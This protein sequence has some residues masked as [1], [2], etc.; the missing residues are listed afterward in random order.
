[1]LGAVES[2][3]HWLSCEAYREFRDGIDPELVRR[4]RVHY[5]R[6]VIKKRKVLEKQLKCQEEDDME[7][8]DMEEDDM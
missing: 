6:K 7:E 4:D 5:L 2:P 3:Q 8:D 1:M